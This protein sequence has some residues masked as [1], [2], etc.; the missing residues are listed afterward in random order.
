MID[1]AAAFAEIANGFSSI[2]GAPY[3]DGAVIIDAQPGGY[4]DNGVFQPGQPPQQIP[5]RVQ[6]DSLSEAMRAQAGFSDKEYRFIVLAS[7]LGVALNA[8]AKVTVTDAKAP[9][10]FIG[11]WLVSSLQRDPAGIAWTGKGVRA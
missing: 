11:A 2:A 7:G 3:F 5:C 8:D 9:A 4:D 6:I 1:L 10:D